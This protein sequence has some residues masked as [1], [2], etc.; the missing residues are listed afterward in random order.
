MTILNRILGWLGLSNGKNEKL[1]QLEQKASAFPRLATWEIDPFHT[2]IGFRVM[3]M[4][5]VEVSGRFKRYTAQVM[6]SSPAFTDLRVEVEIE[7]ASIETDMPARD[8]YLR[9]PE[10]FDIEKY[11]TITFRSTAIR[12]RPLKRFVLEGELT[13]KGVT[14]AVNLEGELKGLVFK[15]LVGE[16]RVSFHL[17]GQIDRRKW[18]LTWH[19]E[20]GDGSIVVDNMVSLDILAEITTPKSLELL[21]QM[22]AQMG[23]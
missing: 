16:P 15:D 20:T 22:L 19:M 3:H 23:G 4:G 13:M 10:F 1:R 9:S 6:G 8:A 18:G 7:A 21:R 17:T 5:L 2:T 12:W 11:P 14:H